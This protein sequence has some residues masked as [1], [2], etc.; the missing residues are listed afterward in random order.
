MSQPTLLEVTDPITG[1]IVP[2]LL[3]TLEVAQRVEG[4]L[5]TRM[6]VETDI[7]LAGVDTRTLRITP[8]QKEITRYLMQTLGDVLRE[9]QIGAAKYA[10][11]QFAAAHGPNVVSMDI[12]RRAKKVLSHN[13]KIAL[14]FD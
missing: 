8:E 2:M 7:V 11:E 13:D 14:S 6:D 5:N 4:L 10:Q 9:D 12:A 3:P 1:H